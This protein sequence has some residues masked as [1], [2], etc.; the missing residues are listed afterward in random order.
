MQGI[1][2]TKTVAELLYELAPKLNKDPQDFDDIKKLFDSNWIETVEQLKE[3]SE[4]DWKNE[5]KDVPLG[6]RK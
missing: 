3:L 1:Q 4:E 6:L 2:N 5:L